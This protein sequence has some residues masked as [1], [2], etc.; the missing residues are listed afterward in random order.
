MSLAIGKLCDK[1]SEKRLGTAFAVSSNRAL[2]AFHCIGDYSNGTILNRE[3]LIEFLGGARVS[4][5]YSAG[6]PKGDYAI[7]SLQ[8]P[9]PQSLTPVPLLTRAIPHEPFRSMGYPSLLE[10]P[11]ITNIGGT[12]RTGD[13]SIFGGVSAIQLFSD[14]GAH[15]L[16]LQGMSGA[17]VLVRNHP[18]AAIGLIRWNP[19]QD[20]SPEF[21]VGGIV[22]SCPVK[23]IIEKHPEFTDL[24]VPM[25]YEKKID[26]LILVLK[27][28]NTTD[29]DQLRQALTEIH[30]EKLTKTEIGAFQPEWTAIPYWEMTLSIGDE[31]EDIRNLFL[32]I[33]IRTIARSLEELIPRTVS[34]AQVLVLLRL[35]ID[36]NNWQVSLACPQQDIIAYLLDHTPPRVTVEQWKEDI[37]K[38]AS[39]LYHKYT[40]V[41]GAL[42]PIGF[43]Y[44]PKLRQI[45]ATNHNQVN[46]PEQFT[47]PHLCKTTSHFLNFIGTLSLVKVLKFPRGAPAIW[48]W[49]NFEQLFNAGLDHWF[50][51]F[52]HFNDTGTFFDYKR[53]F[54]STKDSEKYLYNYFPSTEPKPG[55]HESTNDS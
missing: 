35:T 43:Q 41:E 6:D 15:A 55:S 40:I 53:L 9:L 46:A 29:G 24:V 16:S 13:T 38:L 3:V 17:P 44:K 21:G 37:E 26:D 28:L 19:P 20:T 51:W 42:T 52:Y 48:Y 12:V 25:N 54:I 49:D 2:T 10:G 50:P 33:V 32:K 4:A 31:P 34:E 30:R 8:S 14:E 11:D 23:L 1:F 45:L 39:D 7:L 27:A 5:T 22:F 18:E 36:G 47:N